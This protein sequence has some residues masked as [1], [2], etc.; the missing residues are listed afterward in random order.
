MQRDKEKAGAEMPLS[1]L[2]FF[3][4]MKLQLQV[5]NV[6]KQVGSIYMLPDLK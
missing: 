3:D 6:Q 4:K 1:F 2:L 5:A